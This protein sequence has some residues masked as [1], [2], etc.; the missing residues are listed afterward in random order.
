MAREDMQ[1]K[2]CVDK[3]VRMATARTD[4]LCCR[5]VQC[6][7][8]DLENISTEQEDKGYDVYKYFK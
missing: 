8:Y 6:G 2:S 4:P 1:S 3:V 5:S 7:K